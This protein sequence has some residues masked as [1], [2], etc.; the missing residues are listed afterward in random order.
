MNKTIA[1][2][3]LVFLLVQVNCKRANDLNKDI[4]QIEN[5]LD[6]PIGINWEII[7]VSHGLEVPRISIQAILEDTTYSI[8]YNRYGHKP[9]YIDSYTKTYK[10]SNY[11]YKI[12]YNYNDTT[13]FYRAK[14]KSFNNKEFILG[15]YLYLANYNKLSEGQHEYFMANFDSL[16]KIRGD[17]L[18]ALPELKSN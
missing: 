6:I 10:D 4:M 11:Y 1:L 7:S 12:I 16:R 3:F 17:S 2:I 5:L 18:P 15:K 8:K 9:I 14:G 13:Y